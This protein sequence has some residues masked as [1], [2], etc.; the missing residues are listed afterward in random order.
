MARID[1]EAA[2]MPRAMW[3]GSTAALSET[4]PGDV[5]DTLMSWGVRSAAVGLWLRLARAQFPADRDA[6]AVLEFD[7]SAGLLSFDAW[8]GDTRVYWADDWI[9]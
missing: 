1:V 6:Q 3:T 7:E 9:G 8:V 2:V 5:A 4:L